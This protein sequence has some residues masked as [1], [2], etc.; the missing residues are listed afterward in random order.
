MPRHKPVPGVARAMRPL[1]T[2]EA[3]CGACHRSLEPPDAPRLAEG[4]RLIVESGC[5]ACHDIP[6]FEGVSF[7]G[8]ALDSLG[9][10]VRP[11][12]LEGWLKDPKSYLANS[13]MGNFRLSDTEI[14]GLARPAPLAE[15]AGVRRGRRGRLEEGRHRER[16]APSSASCAA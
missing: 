9:Y 10:K 6:G 8:P 1:E 7:R 15:G 4:R 11:D 14:A 16:Q 12:W 2:I 5:V 3:N 13:K